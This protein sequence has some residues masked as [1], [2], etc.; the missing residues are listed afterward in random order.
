M[1]LVDPEG[2][3]FN[4]GLQENAVEKAVAELSRNYPYDYYPGHSY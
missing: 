3:Q 2:K 1:A 4:D